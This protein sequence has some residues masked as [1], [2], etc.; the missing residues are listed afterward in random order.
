[1]TLETRR[2]KNV[3]I[4]AVLAVCLFG[5]YSAY[6]AALYDSTFLSGWTL[7]ISMLLLTLFNLRKKLTMLPIGSNAIW[8]QFH[9]YTGWLTILLFAL[10]VGWRVPD[11]LVEVTLAILFV[12]VAATG[13]FGVALSRTLPKRLTRRGEEVILERV[14]NFLAALR[15]E[16]EQVVTRSATETSSNTIRDFYS[17]RLHTFFMKPKN[18]LQHLIA[19]NRG[20]FTLLS[21]FDSA[22]RYLNARER[23]LFS[24]LRNLVVKKDELDFHY[25]LQTTLKAWL[26]IHIPATYALLILAVLHLVVVHAF[27][28]GIG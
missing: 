22:D 15:E 9:I 24:D 6:D 8:L 12:V 14:P 25:A 17:E 28:G 19:S 20:L 5:T 2:R 13:I 10:H 18:F 27:S 7:F 16:A 4:T 26:L 11:G 3:L 23:E 21:E 1:M